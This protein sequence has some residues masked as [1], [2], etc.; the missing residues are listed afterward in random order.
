[1]NVPRGLRML[2]ILAQSVA[3]PR[4]TG[5]VVDE[6]GDEAVAEMLRATFPLRC[7]GGRYVAVTQFP[8][9]L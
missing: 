9:V 5:R 2:G 6:V 3:D 4:R 1:M 8:F 7:C